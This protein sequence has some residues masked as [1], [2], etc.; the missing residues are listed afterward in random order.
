MT[1]PVSLPRWPSHTCCVHRGPV[2]DSFP[3]PSHLAAPVRSPVVNSRY[4]PSQSASVLQILCII[5]MTHSG[6]CASEGTSHISQT[7]LCEGSANQLWC[8]ASGGVVTDT[9]AQASRLFLVG[10]GSFPQL[11]REPSIRISVLSSTREQ[12]GMREGGAFPEEGRT[13]RQQPSHSRWPD[14]ARALPV[15]AQNPP[16][17]GSFADQLPEPVGRGEE[18]I[19][20]SKKREIGPHD[21]ISECLHG[22]A[23][24][25]PASAPIPS[26]APATVPQC[27]SCSQSKHVEGNDVRVSYNTDT[28]K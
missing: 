25:F 1:N 19:K 16:A 20:E 2:D 13:S 22:A 8:G 23:I 28:G 21:V 14:P 27:D 6:P 12:E 11:P 5:V 10:R 9:L 7:V 3:S 26:Q 18:G 4:R 15:E 24:E 17:A